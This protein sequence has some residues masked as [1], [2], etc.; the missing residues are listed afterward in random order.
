MRWFYLRRR[1][2]TLP[3]PQFNFNDSSFRNETQWTPISQLPHFNTQP[4][5]FS[6]AL[7]VRV[8]LNI[9]FAFHIHLAPADLPGE[10]PLDPTCKSSPPHDFF[11]FAAHFKCAKP[12]SIPQRFIAS[13]NLYF[14]S[15][16]STPNNPIFDRVLLFTD[17]N[18]N[19]Y[20]SNLIL[21]RQR[22]D[23][24]KNQQW[25]SA[26]QIDATDLCMHRR[27]MK[28]WTSLQFCPLPSWKNNS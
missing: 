14:N 16:W 11:R 18:G 8:I 6:H 15:L 24:N 17:I 9:Y 5:L 28:I 27:V 21:L 25:V 22:A 20:L 2:P 1:H 13:H 19:D 4:P 26:S 3:P 7:Q 12:T 23:A 10:T